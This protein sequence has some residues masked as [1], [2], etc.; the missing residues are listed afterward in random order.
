MSEKFRDVY[1]Q[2]TN[3]KLHYTWQ[4]SKK[5]YGNFRC[6]FCN[7]FTGK[8]HWLYCIHCK[9]YLYGKI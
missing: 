2:G 5:G 3:E 7:K 6:S 4:P 1:R 9:K 8:Y